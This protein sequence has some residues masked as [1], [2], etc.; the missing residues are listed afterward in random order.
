MQDPTT[1][2]PMKSNFPEQ[3]HCKR[4]WAKGGALRNIPVGV[5]TRK[6]TKRSS[7]SKCSTTPSSS[8]PST[9]STSSAAKVSASIPETDPTQIHV[10][11]IVRN[12]GEGLLLTLLS[13]TTKTKSKVESGFVLDV[14]IDENAAVVQGRCTEATRS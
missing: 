13:S 6:V 1:F 2:Q 12:F 3:E 11:P 7:N 8:S 4:Y 9:S 14:I 10:D 5:G